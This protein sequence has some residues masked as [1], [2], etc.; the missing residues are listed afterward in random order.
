MEGQEAKGPDT[1]RL[2]SR[3]EEAI[4][5]DEERIRESF[6]AA[7]VWALLM[8]RWLWSDCKP[9]ARPDVMFCKGI[10]R[11]RRQWGDCERP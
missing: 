5:H 6:V 3:R 1:G 8:R 10:V 2:F 7:S 9:Q 11:N 4:A